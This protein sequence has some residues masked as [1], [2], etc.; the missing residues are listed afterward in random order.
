MGVAAS[1]CAV[2]DEAALQWLFDNPGQL[3]MSSGGAP[4]AV[5]VRM[6][7]VADARSALH[8]GGPGTVAGGRH[9]IRKLRRQ[10]EMLAVSLE[11][12]PVGRVERQLYGNVYKGVT[13]LVTKYLWPGPAFHVTRLCARLGL[14]P[15]MVTGVGVLLMFAAAYL[16]H[17]GR[18]GWGLASAW[19]M[20]FLDTV[21]GKLA[22]VTATSSQFGN[23]LDHGTDML[24]PPLWWWAV[25]E[26]LVR[27]DPGSAGSLWVSLAI[28]LTTYVVS[29]LLEEGFK[30]QFGFNAF[31]W[32][33]FDS[34]FR[35]IVSR[36]NTLLLLLTAGLFTG[37]LSES[38]LVAAAWSVVSVLVQGW[39]YLSAWHV[40][41]SGPLR[42]WLA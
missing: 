11:E 7:E 17:E 41:R 28:I 22:R 16:F 15:N 9:F 29:R 37:M 21:D 8:A 12:A 34:R 23:L 13:D 10:V 1:A 24:H 18:F 26:G 35:L 27:L 39:R 38:W 14:S 40:S 5:G 4:L 20:T 32:E 30:R 6:D 25:T 2:L 19:A 42:S 33:R 31:I 3:L 36:R